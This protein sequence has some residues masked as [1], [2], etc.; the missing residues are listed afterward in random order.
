[1][2]ETDLPVEAE[3]D[4]AAYGNGHGETPDHGT[5][6]ALQLAHKAVAKFPD[7]TKRYQIFVGT[8]AVVS[9][10]L[11][12]MASIAVTKRLHKGESPESILA[13]ITPEE[14][15]GA[16]QEGSSRKRRR[17]PSRFLP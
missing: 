13:E 9:S 2:P 4:E 8:A 16:G 5:L 3:L 10:A 15:E 11:L 1:V 14:I 6:Y 7:L 12:V 17:W